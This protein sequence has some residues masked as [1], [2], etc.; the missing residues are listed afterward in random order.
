MT[1]RNVEI[2]DIIVGKMAEGTAFSKALKLVYSKRNVCI[3]YNEE[4]FNVSL[5]NLGMT[6]RATNPL[7]RAKMR[8]IGD[9]VEFCKEN[10]ITEIVN[11][12]RISGIEVFKTI[13]DY[14]WDNMTVNEKASFLIDTV[15]RNRGN[16]RAEI[17]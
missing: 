11:F 1:Q 15:E 2:M 12:G 14:C 4:D 8:T 9:V 16:V 17:A 7:L 10:Q 6:S 3:P 5:M 13:L